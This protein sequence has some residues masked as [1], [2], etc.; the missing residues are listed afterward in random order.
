MKMPDMQIVE[1]ADGTFRAY[2]ISN[3]EKVPRSFTH[4]TEIGAKRRAWTWY[5]RNPHFWN[6]ADLPKSE[7]SLIPRVINGVNIPAQKTHGLVGSVW[8]INRALDKRVRIPADQ[9]SEYAS[10]GYV[11][12]GPRSK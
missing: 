8:M 4:E 9:E 10:N 6:L 5:D 2:I 7:D 12:G 11:R 1:N 3:G